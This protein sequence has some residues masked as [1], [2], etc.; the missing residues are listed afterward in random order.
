[1]IELEVPD[2][3]RKEFVKRGI[4]D[5]DVDDYLRNLISKPMQSLLDKAF[6][7]LLGVRSGV[8]DAEELNKKIAL[9]V[10]DAQKTERENYERKRFINT[11]E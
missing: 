8:L 2:N 11:S 5:E 4:K 1:V 10:E 9:T 6:D 3:F 7:L